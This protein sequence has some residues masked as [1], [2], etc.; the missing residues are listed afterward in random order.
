MSDLQNADTWIQ[1]IRHPQCEANFPRSVKSRLS[2]FQQLL[3]VQTFR[4]DR[5]HTAISLFINET[6]NV[7]SVE[8]PV[9]SFHDLLQETTP[10]H[11]ILLVTTAGSDPSQELEGECVFW[12]SYHVPVSIVAE[13]SGIFLPW[14]CECIRFASQPLNRGS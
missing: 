8:P 7:A 13:S 12:R 11:P 4:P 5:L 9:F 2:A 14:G 10:A 1:W 3:L 6:L